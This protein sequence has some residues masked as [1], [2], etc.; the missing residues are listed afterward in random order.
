[1][2]TKTEEELPFI[3]QSESVAIHRA[4]LIVSSEQDPVAQEIALLTDSRPLIL[5]DLD[6]VVNPLRYSPANGI[7][8]RQDYA[9]WEVHPDLPERLA[10]ISSLAQIVW[11][12]AWE[13]ESNMINDFF[14]IPHYPWVEWTEKPY[15]GSVHLPRIDT[16]KFPTILRLVESQLKDTTV[17]WVDDELGKDVLEYS[18]QVPNLHVHPVDGSV[19]L[20]ATDWSTIKKFCLN[21]Q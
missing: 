19:G 13:S 5:L 2:F 9:D 7:K 10:S 3:T 4:S 18:S 20:T 21:N 1:M 15:L 11:A 16:W 17:L 8:V 12:S 14:G 6:G